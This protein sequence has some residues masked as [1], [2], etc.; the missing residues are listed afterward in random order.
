MVYGILVIVIYNAVNGYWTLPFLYCDGAFIA[1]GSLVC[2]AGLSLCTNLGA[3]DIFTFMGAKKRTV[4]GKVTFY[5]YSE[6]KKEQRKVKRFN[7][8]P[9]LIAGIIFIIFS[10]CMM[11]VR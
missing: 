3:F 2:I 6:K 1:G 10:L 11:F 8:V 9:Y 5:D 7:W 4:S